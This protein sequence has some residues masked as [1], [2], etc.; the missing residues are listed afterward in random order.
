MSNAN[1]TAPETCEDGICR[2]PCGNDS[3]CGNGDQCSGAGR[4]CPASPPRRSRPAR[5]CPPRRSCTRALKNF[6]VVAKDSAGKAIGYKGDITWGASNANATVAAG[7][8]T[9]GSSDGD[10]N[11][12]ATVGGTTCT[13]AAAQNYANGFSGVR[14][15]VADLLSSE[16]IVGAV[17]SSNTFSARSTP[18][19]TAARFFR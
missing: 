13:P 16:P 11:I 9:G 15:I 5:C 19:R 7:V 14:V 2:P 10:V 3:E 1:C 17:V 4:A 6:T 8:A 12:T 18:A